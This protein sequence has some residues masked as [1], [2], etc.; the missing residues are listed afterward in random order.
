MFLWKG[1]EELKEVNICNLVWTTR[2]L[3][4]EYVGE[5]DRKPKRDKVDERTPWRKSSKR[6][7]KKEMKW[8]IHLNR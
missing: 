3:E 7:G 8:K 2:K 6:N 4:N 1:L 5:N